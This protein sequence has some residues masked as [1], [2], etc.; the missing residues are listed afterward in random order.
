MGPPLPPAQNGFSLSAPGKPV[1]VEM[2]L[3]FVCPFSCKMFKTVQDG[4]LPKFGEK[5]SF[6]VHQVVQPWHAQGTW[7]HE[8]C[9]AVAAEFPSQY[10]EYVRKVIE[11]YEGGDFQD[12]STWDQSRG[13]VYEDLFKIADG[14]GGIEVSKLR[15]MVKLAGTGNAGNQVT[16]SIKWA[17]KLHRT[18]GVHVTP[19]VF[20]NGLEAGIVS[21][22]WTADE[23]S[24][25]LEPMGADFFQGSKL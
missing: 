13:Q 11:A 8:V 3:D 7:V 19:T 4:V 25:F 16:Q 21:S 12:E 6:V 9:L 10:A 18:R 1:V 17:C 14:V 15:D 22:G 5:V 24:K 2:F 20:V 23:W